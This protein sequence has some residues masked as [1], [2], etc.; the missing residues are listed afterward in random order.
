MRFS[1]SLA[2]RQKTSWHKFCVRSLNRHS[3]AKRIDTIPLARQL[4]GSIGW[5]GALVASVAIVRPA[6]ALTIV[7]Y[8][9]PTTIADASNAAQI[10]SAIDTAIN[11]IDSLYS[12]SG[13]MDIV[14]NAGSGGFLGQSETSY[15]YLSYGSYVTD[16]TAVSTSEPTNSVLSS[17][18]AHLFSGNKPI[19]DGLV[20][21]TTADERIALGLSTSTPCFNSSGNYVGGCH[22]IYDGVVT[23]N[24]S[25]SLN[26]TTTPVAGEYSAVAGMEHE[27]NEMLGGGGQG[28]VL[29]QIADGNTIYDDDVGVLDL[30]RYSAPGTKSFT[31]SGSATSYLSVNGGTTSTVCFNQNSS[32]DM[33]DFCTDNNVQSAVADTGIAPSYNQFSPEF[34]MM[35]S[36]GYDGVAV[37]EPGSL[38]LLGFGI[39][40]LRALR[41]GRNG[42][43]ST[44]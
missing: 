42:K 9:D 40:G 6:V 29:N 41:R 7:P 33:G 43:V 22:Q 1:K 24:T 12:N 35:E 21:I 4:L 39:A 34:T 11:T 10:E 38:A 25:I 31:T 19:G 5:C 27:L 3:R 26:Y 17:A 8:F 36:I 2:V 37:P 15:N 13:T 32:Y 28:S 20:A 14:F 16:L 18:V 30:Y 44:G 23:L